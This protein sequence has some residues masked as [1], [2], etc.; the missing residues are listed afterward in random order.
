MWLSQTWGRSWKKSNNDSRHA[1]KKKKLGVPAPSRPQCSQN[2]GL[3]SLSPASR[4]NLCSRQGGRKSLT[5]KGP[6]WTRA[7]ASGLEATRS[8]RKFAIILKVLTDR[9]GIERIGWD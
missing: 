1:K 8:E 9:T 3:R 2:D 4:I 5:D 7:D 6:D